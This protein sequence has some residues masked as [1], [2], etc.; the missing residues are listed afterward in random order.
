[1]LRVFLCIKLKMEIIKVKMSRVDYVEIKFFRKESRL[2]IEWKRDNELDKSICYF[3]S[4]ELILLLI[5]VF[6]F[7]RKKRCVLVGCFNGWYLFR[8]VRF[9]SLF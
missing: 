5:E 2:E 1:M 3:N 9:F 4:E 7:I 6:L 8:I